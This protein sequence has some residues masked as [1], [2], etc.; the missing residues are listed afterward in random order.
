MDNYRLILFFAAAFL[1]MMVWQQWQTDYGP[2]SIDET[3]FAYEN[4]N[5]ESP[6]I[7][8]LNVEKTTVDAIPN[9][10]AIASNDIIDEPT[11]NAS[12]VEMNTPKSVEQKK[13]HVETDTFNL[14]IDTK[15]GS[16]V[17]AN[18]KKYPLSLERSDTQF[19]LLT[20]HPANYFI[21]QSGLIASDKAL[22]PTH[23]SLYTSVSNSYVM[24][25]ADNNL[26]VELQ[27][28]NATGIEV[29]KRYTFTRNSHLIT[30]NHIVKNQSNE[31]WTGREY[32]QLQRVRPSDDGQSVFIYTYTGGAIFSDENKY[33]K[34]DF[35]EMIDADLN[36][37]IKGGWQGMLQHYFVSAWV[38]SAEELN[39]FYSKALNTG[40]FVLGS[41]SPSKTIEPGK[42][43]S[44]P[45][46][47]YAGPK[48]QN[49]LEAISEGLELT[50]D[51]GWLTIIAKPLYWVMEKVHGVVGNWGWAIIILTMMIKLIFFKLSEASYKSMANMRKVAP[52]LATLK[53]R[54][55]DDKAK[56]NQAMMEMYKK[57]KINPLGGCLPML[58]QIPVFIALYW[59]L[60]ESVELRQAPWILWIEDLAIKD[61]YFVLPLL[62]GITMFIQQKL[63]PAPPDPMQ[64]KIMMS[65]PIVFTVF[66]AF[67]PAGLVL[68]WFVNNLLSISQ[69]WYITK[70]IEEAT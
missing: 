57:E 7:N 12:S 44:F 39:H 37:D 4:E 53:E 19:P 66:F 46:G 27:W 58:V 60:L 11:I 41:Y 70:K 14:L 30:I 54:F 42:T 17:K 36:R 2:K 59:V 1:S 33:E 56:L 61:P 45:V 9:A 16:I 62:M 15:G 20:E 3:K 21:A 38:P 52:R 64:A 29:T 69:Q 28:K 63:N 18:L 8:K 40:R 48:L 13:I 6:D 68:Y 10:P 49:E 32:H 65:L 25:E 35:D 55:G 67:F 50:V 34:I 26:V 23:D 47:F 31:K 22:A 24:N 5:R 51:Y 43:N